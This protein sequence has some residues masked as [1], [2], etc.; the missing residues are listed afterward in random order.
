MVE[1]ESDEERKDRKRRHRDKKE[2]SDR[3]RRR[4]SSKDRD[5]DKH[6]KKRK[7]FFDVVLV[8][9]LV[10]TPVSVEHSP[11]KT[12]NTSGGTTIGRSVDGKRPKKAK[13]S[14]ITGAKS[15]TIRER[16]ARCASEG[17]WLGVLGHH[18]PRPSTTRVVEFERDNLFVIERHQQRSTAV[19]RRRC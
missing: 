7:V 3:K 10:L 8:A 18:L 19:L 14:A 13:L 5:D 15:M 4:H 12:R 11:T 9:Y 1:S 6:K 2:K 16:K 17:R